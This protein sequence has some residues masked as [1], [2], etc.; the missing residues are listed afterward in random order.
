M[1]SM[2]EDK[3]GPDLNLEAVDDIEIIMD[4]DDGL[5]PSIGGDSDD[6]AEEHDVVEISAVEEPLDELQREHDELRELYL[7]KLAEF[8]NFRKRT[9]RE[10]EELLRTAGE[11]VVLELIPVL[12]NFER[13]LQHAPD[14]ETDPFRQG[15]VMIYNQLWET[16]QREGLERMDPE[17]KPFEPEF[18]EAVQRIEDTDVAPGTVVA[19]HAKGYL[20]AGK[21]IRPAMVSVA[22]EVPEPNNAASDE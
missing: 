3:N 17:D 21:L 12:D 6:E 8:D 4:D 13:A 9:E 11:N 20:F 7:R 2:P 22:V 5:P 14:V 15:V 10:R 16:L 18:H 19:V 1:Y